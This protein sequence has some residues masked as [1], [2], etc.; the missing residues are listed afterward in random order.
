MEV[1]G[2]LAAE[3]ATSHEETQLYEALDRSNRAAMRMDMATQISPPQDETKNMW[4]AT[5][6]GEDSAN[7]K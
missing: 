7:K 2:D 6:K 1:E 4:C 5:N 3:L